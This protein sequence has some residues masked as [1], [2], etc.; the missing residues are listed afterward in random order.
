MHLALWE[1]NCAEHKALF[2][3]LYGSQYCRVI[4]ARNSRIVELFIVRYCMDDNGRPADSCLYCHGMACWCCRVARKVFSD[5]WTAVR[6]RRTGAPASYTRCRSKAGVWKWGSGKSRSMPEWA[7]WNANPRLCGD[8]LKLLRYSCPY[9]CDWINC[10]CYCFK[11]NSGLC[12]Y[13][14]RIASNDIRVVIIIW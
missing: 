10:D 13:W 4:T 3:L 8:S 9:S 11:N 6:P 7:V 14:W 12:E 2:S 1:R 5:G